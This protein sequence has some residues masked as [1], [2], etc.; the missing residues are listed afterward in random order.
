VGL[1]EPAHASVMAVSGQADVWRAGRQH[2]GKSFLAPRAPR[3]SASERA[4]GVDGLWGVGPPGDR[5]GPRRTGGWQSLD[6]GAVWCR[7]QGRERW[8]ARGGAQVDGLVSPEHVGQGGVGALDGP[9]RSPAADAG[10]ASNNAVPTPPEQPG[11][12]QGHARTAV[13]C[14]VGARRHR[15]WPLVLAIQPRVERMLAWSAWRR[16]P[17]GVARYWH[18]KRRAGS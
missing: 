11:G 3:R 1:A 7:G 2:Q 5:P 12:L 10:G 8:R 18:D 4:D 16:W 13:P 6:R 9:A 14:S 15:F 17:Q